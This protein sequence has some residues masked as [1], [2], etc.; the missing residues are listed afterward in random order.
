M[1][2]TRK[3]SSRCACS[4]CVDV[5]SRAIKL[6][7]SSFWRGD[8]LHDTGTII[9]WDWRDPESRK[10]LI[11][12]TCHLCGHDGFIRK[13]SILSRWQGELNWRGLCSPCAQ[14]P[15]RRT[16][17]GKYKNPFG[18]VI[19]FDKS[20]HDHNR[21]WVYCPN[22]S[23]CGGLEQRRVDKY[24]KNTQP[25]Y[26]SRCLSDS[27]S[28]RLK[29]AWDAGRAIELRESEDLRLALL[30]VIG[31]IVSVWEEERNQKRPYQEQLG[32][33]TQAKV[34]GRIGGPT[35]SPN[36]ARE[37]LTRRK[38][39]EIFSGNRR[40]WDQLIEIIIPE[41]ERGATVESIVFW[42]AQRLNYSQQAA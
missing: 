12:I 13:Q 15:V 30:E 38:V 37:R 17:T 26:C 24:N 29:A 2:K 22:Y 33:V 16:L 34:S 10:N 40:W 8:E 35:A 14:L 32:K 7:D 9:R 39:N 11:L 36:L 19:D 25:F 1:D 31:A 41:I 28:S 21:A 5:R 4:K 20:P 3:P 6:P 27:R 23:S 18:A 42:L